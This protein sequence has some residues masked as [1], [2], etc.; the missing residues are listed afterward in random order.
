M[1]EQRTF[2]SKSIIIIGAGVAGLSAGCYARMNGFDT[3]IFEMHDLPGGL[4]TTW[5]RKEYHFDGCIHYLFG[6]GAGEPFNQMWQELGALNHQFFEPEELMRIRAINGETLIVYSDP[7]KL[8][9]HMTEISPVDVELIKTLCKGVKQFTDF[10]LSILQQKPKPLMSSQDWAQLGLKMTPY[11]QPLMKWGTISGS[12][13]G[14]R[15]EN[16]FLKRAVPLM[17]AWPDAPVM[18]GMQLLASLHNKNAGF[19]YGGSLEFARSIEQRYLELGGELYYKSQVDKIITQDGRA[20]GVRLYNDE[21]YLADIVIS[22]ADGHE[23][24]FEMLGEEFISPDLEKRFDGHMPLH[25]LVYVS[26]GVNRDLS[27][28]P[29]WVHLLLPEPVKIGGEEQTYL[30]VK[31]FSFDSSFAPSGKAAMMVM[32]PGRYGFWQRIYGRRTY[33]IEQIQVERQVIELLEGFYPGIQEQIE[34]KDVA[35]PLSYE[36]FTGNWQGSACGWLLTKDTMMTMIQGMDK[37]LPKLENFYMAGQWVEPGGSLPVV[38]MSGRNAI[39]MICHE[40]EQRFVTS[41]PAITEFPTE[42][43]PIP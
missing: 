12:E 30:S 38:A 32:L 16:P 4:C 6:S 19:P 7:E 41:L 15:F 22:A 10:D 3:K 24:L 36:R 2:K 8:A 42:V 34:V 18:A 20:V 29:H 13:F 28:E 21:I 23:T 11:I 31:Q 14:E 17:F 27:Q 37:T 35:T 39:Q 26:L 43:Q 5:K 9:A 1:A 40:N 33:D 25:P